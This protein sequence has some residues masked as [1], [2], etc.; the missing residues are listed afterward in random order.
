MCVCVCVRQLSNALQLRRRTAQHRGGRH[1]TSE[2]CSSTVHLSVLS[3]TKSYI[4]TTSQRLA[5]LKSDWVFVQ[6]CAESD[7][8]SVTS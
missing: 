3:A 5:I 6:K 8:P 1:F 2:H 4:L 7:W